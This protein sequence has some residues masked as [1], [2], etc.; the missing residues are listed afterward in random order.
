MVLCCV[1]V[2][3][4]VCMHMCIGTY[5]V[6]VSVWVYR[7]LCVQ[8][9]FVFVGLYDTVQPTCD[10]VGICNKLQTSLFPFFNQHVGAVSCSRP[11]CDWHRWGL[12][13]RVLLHCLPEVQRDHRRLL[14]LQIIRMVP[15]STPLPFLRAVVTRKAVPGSFLAGTNPS[16][17]NTSQAQPCPCINS[18][19]SCV[20]WKCYN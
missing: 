2:C 20:T 1:C 8:V 18:T 3:V 19:D 9:T 16:I 12:L 15:L 13:L 17:W 14:L 7:H 6:C 4:C 11:H 10:G 5:T